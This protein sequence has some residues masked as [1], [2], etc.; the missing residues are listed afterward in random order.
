M[1]I[2]IK[3]Y[4]SV[5]KKLVWCFFVLLSMVSCNEEFPELL[6]EEYADES[7]AGLEE[8]KVLYIIIDSASGESIRAAAPPNILGLTANSLYT[9]NGLGEASSVPMTS[10]MG[11][12]NLLTGVES[13]KHGV[14]TDDFM[15]NQLEQYPSFL[16]LI[17][18][19][20]PDLNTV[21]FSSSIDFSEH[22]TKDAKVEETFENDDVQVTQAVV[23][24]LQKSNP[25]VILAQ[26]HGVEN[27]GD[28]YGY[29]NTPEYLN[30]IL[31]VD[32][33]VGDIMAALKDRPRYKQENWLV[34]ITSNKG[35]E[36]DDTSQIV[37]PFEDPS[38][39][40]FTLMYSYRFNSKIIQKPVADDVSYDGFGV[41][42]TYSSNNPVNATL[43]DP[44]L[45]NLGA[46]GEMTIQMM[47]KNRV[48]DYSYPVFLSK[49]EYAFSGPG[50]QLFL[51]GDFWTLSS[52][53]SY[54]LAG[55]TVSDG[56]WHVITVVFIRKEGEESTVKIYTDGVFNEEVSYDYTPN[57]PLQNNAPLRIGYIPNDGDVLPDLFLTNLQIYDKALT[58][59]D[60]QGI[61]CLS[62]INSSHPFYGSLKGFWPGNESEGRTLHE[63]T[64]TYG[65]NADFVLSGPFSWRDFSDKSP[66]VCPPS[67]DSF[68]RLVPNSVDVPFQ[69]FQWLG[70]RIK[71]DWDLDSRGWSP[72]YS[73]IQP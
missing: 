71:P 42:Y 49:R 21:A 17:D 7:I 52:S 37:N 59:D 34:V 14:L 20:S 2:N 18:E 68:Y 29:N 15:D 9:F 43:K 53:I 4:T 12:A 46:E 50:W 64:G 30:A 57:D 73:V 36:I 5:N 13:N 56:Q 47:I 10:A 69:I 72:S 24:Q 28:L 19:A 33:Y 67:P 8:G 70:V 65:E 1:K 62:E 23:D 27:A 41:K 3:F 61:Y 6:K 26:F 63:T 32:D 58:D 22:F 66:N 11:W 40:T 44:T 38:R 55:S 31:E 25:D 39:N 35:G 60:I 45:F 16:T 54:E 51:K 48:G